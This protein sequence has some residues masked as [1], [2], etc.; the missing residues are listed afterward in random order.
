[1]GLDQCREEFLLVTRKFRLLTVECTGVVF[2]E[3][4][5]ILLLRLCTRFLEITLEPSLSCGMRFLQMC[6]AHELDILNIFLLI[7]VIKGH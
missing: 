6:F 2:I 7:K 4:V 1:M 3:V 5:G